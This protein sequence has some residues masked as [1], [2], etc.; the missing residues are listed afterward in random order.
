VLSEGF[1]GTAAPRYADLV[2]LL[3][4][5]MGLA[6]VIG[7]VLARKRMFRAHAWCQSAVVLVNLAIVVLLMVPSFHVNV[8]PNIPDKLGKA[9]YRL[10]TTHAALGSITEIAAF[11]ILLV[12]GTNIVPHPFRV[13]N[14]KLWMRT[15][16]VLWWIVLILGLA[17]YVRWYVPGTFQKKNS[18]GWSRNNSGTF[19]SDQSRKQGRAA[20]FANSL[21]RR[22]AMTIDSA[23]ATGFWAF[24]PM[25]PMHHERATLAPITRL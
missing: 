23:H 9:Y 12:A 8:S 11:Y 13:T 16:L 6:L 3:E 24:S 7:A 4:L 17:T 25:N 19:N 18:W 14:F 1:L 2:L 15:V 22:P 21:R 10:P 20:H 5:G